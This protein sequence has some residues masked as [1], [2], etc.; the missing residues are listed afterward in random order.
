[1]IQGYT[2]EL[3]PES[4]SAAAPLVERVDASIG[5]ASTMIG[6]MLTEFMRR[7]LRNGV[8]KIDEEM[9]DYVAEKVDASIADRTPYL[10]KTAAEVAETTARAAAGDL[11]GVE[12]QGLE[13]KTDEKARQLAEQI[14]ETERRAVQTTAEAAERLSVKIEGTEK[15][16]AEK[17]QELSQQVEDLS[18]RSRKGVAYF[19]GRLKVV[20]A[21]IL[22]LDGA[23]KT[24][25]ADREAEHTARQTEISELRM[26]N[27]R[28]TARVTELERPRGLRALFGRVFG[29]LFGRLFRRGQKPAGEMPAEAKE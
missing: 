27:E 15:Q 19:K 4:K 26:V 6:A 29:G 5:E 18:T 16:A 2:T 10:E 12:I 1:V 11:V 24:E 21:A 3:T 8:I 20:E 14:Q 23:L 9:H 22:Q 28:L 13:R 25:K 17:A 7:T